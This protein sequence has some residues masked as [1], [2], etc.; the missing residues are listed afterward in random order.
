MID[1]LNIK[2]VTEMRN[3][4]LFL[5]IAMIFALSILGC[6]QAGSPIISTDASVDISNYNSLPVGVSDILPDGTPSSG[7]GALGLFELRIDPSTT[8]AELNSLRSSA[9]TDVLETVDITNFLHLAPCTNCVKIKSVSLDSNGNIV[10]SIG[11][12]HP[13]SAGDPLKPITGRNRADLHV[14]NV[15]GI[16]ISSAP[17]TSFPSLGEKIAGFN[18]L[19]ADGYTGYLDTAIDDFYPTDASIH[20]YITHFDDYSAGNFSASNAMGFASVTDPPPTGNLV[21]AMGCDY[22][23]QDYVFRIDPSKPVDF[24][25]AV[26]CTYAL[27]AASKSQRFSPEYRVP[28]HNKK[29]ASEVAVSIV[30]NHLKD[31]DTASTAG[32]EIRVVDISQGVSVGIELDEM[33]SD[34]SVANI[35]VEIPQ[36]MTTPLIIPGGSPVSGTGHSPSDPLLYTGTITNTS[37]AVEGTYAGLVKVKD[38]YAPGQNVAPTLNGMDGIKRV[39]PGQIPTSGLF[40]IDEFATYQTFNIDVAIQNE[41]PICDLAVVTAIPANGWDIGTP[42][43]FDASGSSDPD[44]DSLSYKWDFDGDGSVDKKDVD[45]IAQ[46]AVSIERGGML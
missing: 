5:S 21:M 12:K 25:Y 41:E 43:E 1:N 46:K 40:A 39:E 28:Q 31:G 6:S 10:V 38:T 15:E 36:V 29:A 2:K 16:V 23:F 42:V 3:I 33:L 22:N 19:N 35:M 27:S 18:L 20:P 32:I 4:Y 34:S 7:M 11:I 45:I 30:D 44:G 17:S 37:S 9:L 24:I 13:F 8:E 14:F 26:G